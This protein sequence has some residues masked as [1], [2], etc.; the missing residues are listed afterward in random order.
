MSCPHTMVAC[1]VIVCYVV[2]CCES[3]SHHDCAMSYPCTVVAPWVMPCELCCE[4]SLHYGCMLYC[5]VPYPCTLWV[6]LVLQ[7]HHELLYHEL[8]CVSCAMSY[9][10]TVVVCHVIVCHVV[11]CCVIVHCVIV[12][13]VIA[14]CVIAHRELSLH[15]GCSMSCCCTVVVVWVVV[16][17]ELSSCHSCVVCHCTVWV[18]LMW[19]V[20]WCIVVVPAHKTWRG[21]YWCRVPA[22]IH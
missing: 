10:C 12:C 8:H 21:L 16:R 9:P 7:L 20:M 22:Q 14:H 18:V 3:S 4:S 19:C 2:A 17:C 6:V 1:H 15:C 11:V 13:H 5:C